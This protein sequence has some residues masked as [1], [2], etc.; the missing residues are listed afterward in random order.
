MAEF[1]QSPSTNDTR[2]WGQVRRSSAA[3]DAGSS[4]RPRG[5]EHMAVRES[6]GS[7]TSATGKAT[8]E[9]PGAPSLEPDLTNDLGC[10]TPGRAQ[11]TC[12]CDDATG[13]VVDDLIAYLHGDD[14]RVLLVPERRQHR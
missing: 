12:S 13:G 14:E 9:G 10:T 8:V 2:P 1:S 4:T 3:V 5:Q 11:Y 7:S 6:V